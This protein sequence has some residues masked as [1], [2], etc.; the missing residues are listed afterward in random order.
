MLTS[1]NSKVFFAT[2]G[3]FSSDF[4]S[5]AFESSS[6]LTSFG[7][8]SSL[9]STCLFSSLSFAFSDLDSFFNSSVLF[10]SSSDF[11]ASILESSA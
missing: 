1:S 9:D 5:L 11:C 8:D 4:I 10:T 7:S 2:C 3:F 6:S